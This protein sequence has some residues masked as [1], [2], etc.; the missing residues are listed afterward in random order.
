[1]CGRYASIK[2]PTELAEEFQA[3][4]ATDGAAPGAD[5]N[6]AP[7]KP[8]LAVVQRHPRDAAGT[9]DPDTTVRSLRVMR[10][11]LIP[12]WAKDA[13]IGS[14]M[15]NARAES[16]ADKPAYRKALARRRCLLPAGGWYEWRAEDGRKQPYFLTRADGGSL[17]LAGLWELW[18]PEPDAALVVSTAV[19]TTSAVGPL[20]DIHDRMPLA[21]PPQAWAKWLDP[22]DEDVAE[23]LVPPPEDFVA[24]LELRPVST[25]VN[26]VRNEGADLVDRVEPEQPAQTMLD[27]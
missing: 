21:L 5:F 17:A 16:A 19:V 15:I 18:R 4:D 25:R 10:W 14:R 11:G 7:T 26:D 23:L 27:L 20:T 24:G 9:P 2:G 12:S 3:V 13:S 6:V 22:D 8:V 1:M